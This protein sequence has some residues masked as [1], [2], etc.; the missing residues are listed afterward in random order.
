MSPGPPIT[1]MRRWPSPSRWRVAVRP[2]VPVGR[3]DRRRVV[4]R[5]AGRV[6][7]DER[8]AARPELGL[9][10]LAEVGEDGDDAESGAGRARPRSSRDPA[11]AGP[12][13]RTGRPRGRARA[14]TRL[15]APDDLERPLALELVEDHLEQRRPLGPIAGAARSPCSRMT[16]STRRRV[17]GDTS[18][19][20]LIT[21][22]TVGTDTPAASAT[23]AIVGRA[24]AGA[25]RDA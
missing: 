17:S 19:R 18:A 4:E 1:P 15:D 13:A 5:L 8:D 12:A 11:C 24:T 2:A 16:A 20:P 22:D 6:D 25:C 7:D 3:A 9:H 21:F 14:A 10:R 23:S